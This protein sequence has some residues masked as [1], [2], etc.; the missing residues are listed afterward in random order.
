VTNDN[1][2]H[3]KG[4]YISARDKSWLYCSLS[5]VQLLKTPVFQDNDLS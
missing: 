2:R 5:H 1:Q 3:S 4:S